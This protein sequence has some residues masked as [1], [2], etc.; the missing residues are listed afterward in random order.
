M[1][2]MGRYPLVA[3]VCFACPLFFVVF[4][5]V[6][7]LLCCRYN[8]SKGDEEMFK[9]LYEIANDYIPNILK[10]SSSASANS[11]NDAATRNP[12][13]AD[14]PSFFALV[15]QFYDG[16]CLWEEGS[17]TPVLHADWAKKLVQSISRFTP[18]CRSALSSSRAGTFAPKPDPIKNDLPELKAPVSEAAASS[19]NDN[20]ENSNSASASVENSKEQVVL[21]LRSEK[22]RGMRGL[23]TTS[24]KINTSAIKLQLTAQSQVSVPKSRRRSSFKTDDYVYDFGEEA[25]GD[26]EE[27][28]EEEEERRPR[29]AMKPDWDFVAY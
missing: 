26:E 29:K 20:L 13:L 8:Y 2:V 12:N 6:V 5:N 18:S 15:L 23:L 27:D 4:F 21:N 10:R 19:S 1:F 9:E 7:A 25:E 24:G 22:M 14:D 3:S 28:E 11:E 17:H 16:V